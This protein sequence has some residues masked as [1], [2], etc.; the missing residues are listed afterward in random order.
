MK[1]VC[2]NGHNID[3][4]TTRIKRCPVC[5]REKNQKYISVN[6]DI[7]N[8]KKRDAR[9]DP[10]VRAHLNEVSRR[11]KAKA[12]AEGRRDYVAENAARRGLSKDEYL[13][14][15]V[16]E[17]QAQDKKLAAKSEREKHRQSL[18]LRHDAHVR[19][20]HKTPDYHRRKYAER[21]KRQIES[22]RYR[23]LLLKRDARKK[24]SDW[25]VATYFKTTLTKLPAPLV[26][27]GRQIILSRR[28]LNELEQCGIS[29]RNVS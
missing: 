7:I 24:I 3:F 19:L 5:I 25:Y 9:S 12:R 21:Y 16:I 27:L 14:V 23:C 15:K 11:S 6:R 28:Y 29:P 17:K 13:N 26:A 18:A 22:E 10:E 8:Q 20:Y 2:R 4:V 1:Y